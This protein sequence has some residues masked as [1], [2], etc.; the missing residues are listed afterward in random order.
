VRVKDI[1]S[2]ICCSRNQKLSHLCLLDLSFIVQKMG[3]TRI[4]LNLNCKLTT[5]TKAQEQWTDTM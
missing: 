5:F 2:S 4:I 1:P 3:R